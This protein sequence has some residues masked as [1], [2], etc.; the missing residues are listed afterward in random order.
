M[1]GAAWGQCEGSVGAV[2][3]REWGGAAGLWGEEI[4]SQRALTGELYVP[5]HSHVFGRI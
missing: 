5:Q 2:Y 4:E 3:H 1:S